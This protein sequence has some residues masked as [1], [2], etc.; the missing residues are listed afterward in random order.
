[1]G[2]AHVGRQLVHVSGVEAVGHEVLHIPSQDALNRGAQEP[3][4]EEA[5]QRNALVQPQKAPLHLSHPGRLIP[6]VH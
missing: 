2:G 3:A 5:V 4:R 1:M 6:E